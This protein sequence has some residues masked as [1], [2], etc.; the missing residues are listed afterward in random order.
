MTFLN[1]SQNLVSMCTSNTTHSSESEL[2]LARLVR[3]SKNFGFHQSASEARVLVGRLLAD[4]V[5]EKNIL[6]LSVDGQLYP[7]Q[8]AVSCLMQ[9]DA[10]DWVHA[11]Y[12]DETVWVLSVL[13]KNDSSKVALQRLNFGEA[14]LEICAR[15]ISIKADLQ[16]DL[17]APLIAQKAKNR[18]S[19]IEATDNTR[20]G[21]SL[22]HADGHMSLHARSAM[23]TAESLLKID[24]AQ[25]HM[26]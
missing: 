7:V 3:Q 20:V 11:V 24:A 26:G 17:Q 19:H 15:K 4:H 22:V 2:D 16:M 9:V 18:K 6:Y 25:I 14:E 8:V 5:H 21:N 10:G 23:V 13:K 12:S 1:S